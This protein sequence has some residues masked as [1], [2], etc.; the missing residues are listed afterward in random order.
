MT[1]KRFTNHDDTI[2]D[3]DGEQ[4][5]STDEIVDKMNELHEER[6]YFERKKWEYWNKFNLAHL[7][8]IN[9]RKE[10]EHIKQTI[11]TMLENERTELGKSVLKQLY[12]AIQ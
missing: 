2:L 7:D 12:E 5:I 8:N 4:L 11:K 6:N 3:T 9:L 10:N 1:A